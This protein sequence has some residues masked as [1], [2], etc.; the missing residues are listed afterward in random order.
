M[1]WRCVIH[2]RGTQCLR[3]VQANMRFAAVAERLSRS[4]VLTL[5]LALRVTMLAAQQNRE[6]LEGNRSAL[7]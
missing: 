1:R 7:G 6:T 5:R 2:T 4:E 3:V